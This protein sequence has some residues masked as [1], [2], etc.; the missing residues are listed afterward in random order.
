MKTKIPKLGMRTVKTALAVTVCLLLFLGLAALGQ[1]LVTHGTGFVASVGAFLTMQEPLFAC[2]AA[3]I[4]MQQT[5]A[6][7]LHSGGGRLLGTAVGGAVGLG[8]MW[9]SAHV[10]GG[11][12]NILFLLVGCM[13]VIWLMLL[14]DRRDACAICAVTFI[15][16]LVGANER[17]LPYLYA[18][19]RILDT[20][21]GIAVSVAVNHVIRPVRGETNEQ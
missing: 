4:C 16:L 10:W 6:H 11:R 1:A 3:V 19:N 8:F 9:I 21:L 20:A 13:L 2:V 18:L 5:V 12:L 15:I 7:S 17:E 14:L